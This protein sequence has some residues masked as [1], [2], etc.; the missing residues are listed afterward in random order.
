MPRRACSARSVAELEALAS[1]QGGV[2]TSRQLRRGGI[3]ARRARGLVTRRTWRACPGGVIVPGAARRGGLPGGAPTEEDLQRGWV[4]ALR[5]G[6][7]AVLSGTL[8]ARIWGKA[9]DDIAPC[10]LIH[11]RSPWRVPG[12]RLVRTSAHAPRGSVG[13]RHGLLLRRPAAA[14]VDALSILAGEE[15]IGL[16]DRALQSRWLTAQDIAREIATRPGWWRHGVKSL[17]RLLRLVEGGTR[18]AAERKM[19]A[20][21]RRAGLKGWTC[22]LAMRDADGRVQAELDFAHEATMTGIEVD[23]Q[24]W[25][26]ASPAYEHDRKRQNHVQLT[27][28]LILRFN[29]TQITSEPDEVLGMI[30]EA[31][32]S[33]STPPC[34]RG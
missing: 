6:E 28:W 20:L 30:R 1:R 7:G 8:A 25:H 32:A 15:Q 33:R 23:G 5:A 21:M 4:A 11:G 16:L 24:A 14:L 2:L 3:S 17:R 29:W 12:L 19:R 34:L 13:R 31:V 26:S 9:V 22:N 10:M 18:S 27:G